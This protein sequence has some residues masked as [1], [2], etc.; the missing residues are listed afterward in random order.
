[1]AAAE[2]R[3]PSGRTAPPQARSGPLNPSQ[4]AAA[5]VK[6]PDFLASAA[7]LPED[8]NKPEEET[9]DGEIS[10][11]LL[12]ASDLLGLIHDR[13]NHLDQLRQ[14]ASGGIN[15]SPPPAELGREYR[16]LLALKVQL[17][18]LFPSDEKDPA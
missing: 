15:P 18:A 11:T 3:N 12:Q 14:Q 1:M 16:S 8:W 17:E 10:L 5:F 9:P 6:D 13:Q 4:A 7:Q 2:T